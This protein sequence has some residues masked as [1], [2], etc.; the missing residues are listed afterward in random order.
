METCKIL[1]TVVLL[2][3]VALYVFGE[4]ELHRDIKRFFT[5][6]NRGNHKRKK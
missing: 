6:N 1:A 2:F 5:S 4:Q 3:L